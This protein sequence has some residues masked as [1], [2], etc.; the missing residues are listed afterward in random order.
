MLLVDGHAQRSD[1]TTSVGGIAPNRLLCVVVIGRVGKQLSVR[2]ATLIGLAILFAACSSADV[3][4]EVIPLTPA[5]TTEPSSTTVAPTTSVTT[6]PVS[7]T[8]ST[9]T[10]STAATSK[11]TVEQLRGE[12]EAFL[13]EARVAELTLKAAPR[14]ADL[15]LLSSWLTG[16][17]LSHVQ[18]SVNM[19]A[20]RGTAVRAAATQLE[21]VDVLAINGVDTA[22]VIVTSCLTTDAIVYV[23]QSG[24]IVDD[25]IFSELITSALVWRADGWRKT[26]GRVLS[27]HA[28]EGCR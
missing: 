8:T 25:S 21:R 7:T 9:P 13:N 5:P 28:G 11:T 24:E 23:E 22:S 18:A 14:N 27:T 17:A 2:W 19:H 3:S 20:E 15:S 26:S 12:I 16:D 10:T 4:N 6:V 1:P